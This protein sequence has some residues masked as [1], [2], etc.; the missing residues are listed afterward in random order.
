MR[1]KF[2]VYLFQFTELNKTNIFVLEAHLFQILICIGVFGFPFFGNLGSWHRYG[3]L[4]KWLK[5]NLKQNGVSCRWDTCEPGQ[6]HTIII[7]VRLGYRLQHSNGNQGSQKGR[8]DNALACIAVLRSFPVSCV[9]II[10]DCIS[11]TIIF[12]LISLYYSILQ[13]CPLLFVIKITIPNF[14]RMCTSKLQISK[15][16]S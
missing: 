9:I 11:E 1:N 15:M 4:A 3:G 2:V 14:R 16:K 10:C 5:V 8:P 13:D 6:R 7:E 12:F